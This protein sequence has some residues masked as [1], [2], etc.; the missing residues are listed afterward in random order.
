S[1]YLLTVD[2]G[3]VLITAAVGVPVHTPARSTDPKGAYHI[4]ACFERV[5]T[6]LYLRPLTSQSMGRPTLPVP[7]IVMLS[8]LFAEA[9]GQVGV[10]AALERGGLL[11]G[12][13]ADLRGLLEAASAATSPEPAEVAEPWGLLQARIEEGFGLDLGPGGLARLRPG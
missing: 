11:A 8:A 1:W 3:V 13:L 5:T 12:A 10:T 9:E 4:A 6:R 2:D 7:S